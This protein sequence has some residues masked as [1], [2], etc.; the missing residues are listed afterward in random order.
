MP[1]RIEVTDI[2][3]D[4][5]T[6]DGAVGRICQLA[7]RRPASTVVTPNVDIVVLAHRDPRLRQAIAAATLVLAD[8]QPIVWASRLRPPGL[9]GRVTGADLVPALAARAAQEGLSLFLCGAAPGVAER[10]A[11]ELR[12][13]HPSLRIVGVAAP[14][15]EELDSPALIEEI[16][17]A[18]ADIL[19]L[20][21][22]A[23][24]QEIWME[25]H[26]ERLAVG[27]AIGAGAGID[28]LAGVQRRAPAWM[29]RAGLEWAYRL[30]REPRRL[31]RRYLVR[32]PLFAWYLL[33][34][35]VRGRSAPQA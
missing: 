5:L 29:Q 13:R 33:R 8:G 23:P 20:A 4:A 14:P 25:R 22:G 26:R 2:A 16:N 30:A 17:G 15:R 27:V 19:V 10:A 7:R 18:R 3:F 1:G 34:W 32:D 35:L 11:E 28:F 31:W 6:L 24:I 21:F 12:R 9:P